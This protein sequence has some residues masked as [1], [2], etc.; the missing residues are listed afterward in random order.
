MRYLLLAFLLSS[1]QLLFAQ[2]DEQEQWYH[3]IF[4]E[5]TARSLQHVGYD[6]DTLPELRYELSPDSSTIY[7][8]NYD[9]LHRVVYTYTPTLGEEQTLKKSKCHIHDLPQL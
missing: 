1:A 6:S 9:G 3:Q 2:G 5:D 8:Y 7:L 4:L